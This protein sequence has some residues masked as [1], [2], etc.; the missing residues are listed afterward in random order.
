MMSVAATA[1]AVLV[2]ASAEAQANCQWYAATSLKQQQ[3][4]EKLRCGFAGP[5]W[6]TDLARHNAWCASVPPDVWKASAQRRDQ[7]IAN[8]ARKAR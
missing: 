1:A 2:P 4:N 5:E 7:M 8:C 3:Q 6:S